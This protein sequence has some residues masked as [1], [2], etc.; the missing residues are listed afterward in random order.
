MIEKIYYEEEAIFLAFRLALSYREEKG[1]PE[2]VFETH[3][4]L[5]Y[6][7]LKHKRKDPPVQGWNDES[8]KRICTNLTVHGKVF[9]K[10]LVDAGRALTIREIGEAF[11]EAGLKWK[12]DRMLNGILAGFSRRSKAN[13]L[14]SIWTWKDEDNKFRYYIDEEAVRFIKKYL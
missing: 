1:T 5:I 6:D 8:V 9:L 13:H 2:E 12:S 14:P 11:K 3:K 10:T 7:L 4:K